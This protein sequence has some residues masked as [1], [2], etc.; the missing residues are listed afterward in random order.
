MHLSTRSDGFTLVE[1]ITTMTIAGILAAV[2]GPRLVSSR[3][4]DERGYADEVAAALR[5]ARSAAIT[6]GCEVRFA[7]DASGYSALQ[8]RA[9]GSHCALTGAW[10]TPVRRGDGR[11]LAAWPPAGTTVTATRTLVFRSDGAV[12]GGA[13]GTIAIGAHS[14][15]IGAAGWVDRQ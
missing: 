15:L 8:H 2:A 7:I 13:P 3:P 10:V 5:Q 1:L 9:A 11:D 4:F 6:S 14:V 12:Q